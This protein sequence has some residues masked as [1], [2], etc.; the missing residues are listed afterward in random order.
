M[1]ECNGLISAHRNLCLPGSS[2]SSASASGVARTTAMHHH[3]W[4]LTLSPRLECSGTISAYCKLDLLGSSDSPTD[5]VLP[6]WPGSSRVLTS[7]DLPTLASQSARITVYLNL[8]V[9]DTSVNLFYFLRQDLALLP[10]LKCSGTIL[11]HY[12]LPL[13]GSSSSYASVSQVAGTTGV[14][15]HTQLLFVF[16]VEMG[17]H[18]VAQAGLE[19]LSSSDPPTWA[20]QSAGITGV[21]HHNQPTS[22]NLNL[23]LAC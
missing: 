10:R 3:A 6:C 1:L 20:S 21:S 18:R 12:N 16:L 5:R 19:L 13:P 8:T 22:V 15:H 11:A 17:F 14:H 23:S 7:G 9:A 2:D 4:G